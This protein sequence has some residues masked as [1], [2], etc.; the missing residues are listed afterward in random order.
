MKIFSTTMPLLL[1]LAS[2]PSSISSNNLT[3]ISVVVGGLGV[4][5]ALSIQP[6][7]LS[8]FQ[9]QLSSRYPLLR[10]RYS[11]FSVD[12]DGDD[13]SKSGSG[14][15]SRIS[16]NSRRR[17]RCVAL[18][19]CYTVAEKTVDDDVTIDSSDQEEIVG[20]VSE[21]NVG[22]D[23]S[24]SNND[25]AVT[26]LTQS[27]QDNGKLILENEEDETSTATTTTTKQQHFW[28]WRNHDV[29]TEVRSPVCTST[30]SSTTSSS[31]TISNKNDNNNNKPKVILLHG[32]GASSTY[33][34]ETMSTLQSNG[35]E[36]HA[37]DVLGQGRSSKPFL[38]TKTT[39]S[40]TLN[41]PYRLY[42]KTT[43]RQQDDDEK[44]Q[45]TATTQHQ[46]ATSSSSL[47]ST[48]TMGKNTNT[49]IQYSINL[50]AKM[51]DDYARANNMDEVILVGNSL[52]S[53]VALSAATGDFIHSPKNDIDRENLFG[54]LAGNNVGERS[55]VKGIC[56]FNCA[57]GLN[58]MNILKNT[59]Y[60]DVQ[61]TVFKWIF[62]V[63][64]TIIFDNEWLLRYALRN[65]VTKELL[66]DALRGLYMCN[67]DRVDDELVDSFYYPAKLGGENDDYGGVI[68]AIRQIYTNDAGLSPMELHAKYPEILNS[69]PLHL[70]WGNEDVVTPIEGDVGKFYCDRVANNRGGK[71]MTT[72]D[73]VRGG[74]IL[75]DDNPVETHEAMMRWI[76]K[77]VL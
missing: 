9:F 37:L 66:R 73:V 28:K 64:N 33:W 74:H 63:L 3:I 24:S 45:A 54:Y 72:I 10:R 71:G 27:E 7:A 65:V 42:P 35:F 18:S 51:V 20:N 40:S 17:R 31:S 26:T 49:T 62:Q 55:R 16:G 67:P 47:S 2:L 38:S 15:G 11:V 60:S 69:I 12:Y 22:S 48:I 41:F 39:S 30:S 61:R 75:F 32:F 76:Q 58:S 25:V 56:L 19:S 70:I 77:K 13:G 21:R 43:T 4:V 14:S 36:V 50:W 52:G 59:S 53:L 46:E 8:D 44:R 6:S 29:F 1:L 57:V 68:E 5:D 34:R 23:S